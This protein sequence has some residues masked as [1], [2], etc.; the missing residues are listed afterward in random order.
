M[1]ATLEDCWNSS[2]DTL[3][4]ACYYELASARIIKTWK[5]IGVILAVCTAVT[6]S[7]SAVSGWA[8]WPNPNEKT[9]WGCL[10]AAACVL[11][12]FNAILEIP[13]RISEEVKRC[14]FYSA[15]RWDLEAFRHKL[16]LDFDL[17]KA[18]QRLHQLDSR[19]RTYIATT[20]P[21]ILLNRA[22]RTSVQASVNM[23]LKKFIDG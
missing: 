13:W 7:A 14:Q 10:A 2:F 15:L 1:P 20:P 4:D 6:A 16:T 8:L 11:A 5:R 12:I 17:L 19:L 9:V 18:E 22:A 23:Q 3:Y 21:D